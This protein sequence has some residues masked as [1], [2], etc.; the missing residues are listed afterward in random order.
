MDDNHKV[1]PHH[2]NQAKMIVDVLFDSRTFND[3]LSR[4][5]L[6]NVEDLMAMYL[7]SN[8]ESAYQIAKFE[9]KHSRG[10]QEI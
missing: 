3:D 6:K 1:D 2:Q 10:K 5:D 8:A 7:D 4:D 9:L